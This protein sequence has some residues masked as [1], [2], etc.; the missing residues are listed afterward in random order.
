MFLT[1][2]VNILFG[3]LSSQNLENQKITSAKYTVLMIRVRQY[4]RKKAVVPRV[5]RAKKVFECFHVI[6]HSLGERFEQTGISIDAQGRG[7][8]RKQRRLP[9]TK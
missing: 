4:E 1:C 3:S 2:N 5:I 6:A 7:D 8:L 9:L